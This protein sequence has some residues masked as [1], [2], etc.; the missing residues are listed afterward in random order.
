MGSTGWQVRIVTQTSNYQNIQNMQRLRELIGELMLVAS[1][2]IR[3]VP[4]ELKSE[5]G[6]LLGVEMPFLVTVDINSID[7]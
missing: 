2:F 5:I 6:R 7:D 4:V 3:A 1:D